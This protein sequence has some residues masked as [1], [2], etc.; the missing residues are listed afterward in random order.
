MN[1]SLVPSLYITMY[2]FIISSSLDLVDCD[3]NLLI[4]M[5]N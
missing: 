4:K 1:N 5:N 2:P 3:V